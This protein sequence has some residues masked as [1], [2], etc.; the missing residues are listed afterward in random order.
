MY[1]TENFYMGFALLF[2]NK[3]FIVLKVT[4]KEDDLFYEQTNFSSLFKWSV[5]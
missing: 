2:Q 3:M 1:G 5:N 4:K